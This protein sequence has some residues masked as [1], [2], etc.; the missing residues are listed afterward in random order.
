VLVPA[1]PRGVVGVTPDEGTILLLA[2]GAELVRVLVSETGPRAVLV[3]SLQRPRPGA[4]NDGENTSSDP[5]S[6][7]RRSTRSPFRT[8]VWLQN[9]TLSTRNSAQCT[10]RRRVESVALVML[11]W[12]PST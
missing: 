3:N 2:D 9:S 8:F 1:E 10:R 5:T 4:V 7:C 6:S 11:W 12:S